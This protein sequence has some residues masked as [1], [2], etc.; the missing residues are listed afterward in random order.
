[1]KIFAKQF[2][3]KPVLSALL[4]LLPALA[5][6]FSGIGFCAWSS[7]RAQLQKIDSMYTTIAVLAEDKSTF[8]TGTFTTEE[9]GTKLWTD[10]T[11][12]VSPQR[13]DRIAQAA[14]QLSLVNRSCMLSA[15]ISGKKGYSSG[16]LDPLKYVYGFDAYR[17]NRAVLALRCT[18]IS[19]TELLSSSPTSFRFYDASF[20]I[21]EVV[22]RMDS[23]DL[24]PEEDTVELKHCLLYNEDGSQIFEVGKTYLVRCGYTDYDIAQEQVVPSDSGNESDYRFGW[25]RACD[26]D[27]HFLSSALKFRQIR[28]PDNEDMG[29][30]SADGTCPK[31]YAIT[32]DSQHTYVYTTKGSLPCI[33]EY[34]GDVWEYLD[35]EEGKVW[36]EKIIPLCRLNYESATAILTDRLESLVSFNTGEAYILE[37]RAITAEEYEKGEAVCLISAPYAQLNGLT[38]GDTLNLDFYDSGYCLSRAVLRTVNNT[39]GQTIFQYPLTEESRMGVQKDYR[40]I[41]IYTSPEQALGPYSFRADTVFVPKASVPEAEQYEDISVPLLNSYI[42]KNGSAESFESYMAENNA[43]GCFLYF[44]QSFDALKESLATLADNALRLWVTGLLVF[45]LTTALPCI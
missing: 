35:S 29:T 5:A 30:Q 1:M 14:P 17:Y 39:G 37:G 42:L 41:G 13:A 21:L 25:I 8:K 28:F 2:L 33:T 19:D 20:E 10:G 12:S 18:A 22:C 40:I 16:S 26:F 4:C 44:D 9:D 38:T 27:G 6:G 31:D 3:R 36:K 45:L 15:H 7:S 43:G 24:P 32:Y 11:V 23:Y 34:E